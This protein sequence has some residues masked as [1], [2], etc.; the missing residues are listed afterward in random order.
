MT[1]SD[2]H[3]DVLIVGAGVV[4]CVL[5]RELAR[6]RHTDGVALKIGVLEKEAD[7]SL[8]TSCRNSGV[9]HSGINYK[10][11]TLRAVL[12]VRGNAMMDGLCADLK[13]PLKRIGKLTVALTEGDLPGLYKQKEQGE[14]NGVPGMEL[15]DN[16]RMRTI[17]PGIEGILGLWTPSSAIILPYALTISAAW[18][19]PGTIGCAVL[20]WF[21]AVSLALMLRRGGALVDLGLGRFGGA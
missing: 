6:Y 15:M 16:A 19:V 21:S 14:A 17:Q 2:I 4:G 1:K 12:N 7:V 3:Y 11:G 9:V 8:G 20:G 5:A 18:L 13:V 10:P